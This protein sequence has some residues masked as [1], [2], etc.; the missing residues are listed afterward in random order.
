MSNSE[1][2]AI[3]VIG[4]SGDLARKKIYPALFALF[5]QH[6][7]PEDFAVF[8]F[9]RSAYSAAEFR[10]KVAEHLTCRYTPDDKACAALMDQ[11]LA[12]CHAH[13]GVYGDTNSYLD[14]FERLRDTGGFHDA[15]K[16]YYMAIPPTVFLET[17]RAMANSGLVPC[18][19]KP[20]WARTVIEKPFGRDRR[21]SDELASGLARVFTERQT[22]RIDHYL[23]K[24]V[25]QNVLAIRFANLIF[26]PIWN[27]EYVESVEIVWKENIGTSGRGGY[28][29]QFGI[30]RDV[31]QNHLLQILAMIA[32]ER[33]AALRAEAV[34]DS[35]VAVL[36]AIAPATLDNSR[37]GQYVAGRGANGR[38]EEGYLDDPTVPPGSLTP[39]F[40]AVRLEVN[41]PRWR[42]VPFKII[43]GKGAD[44]KKNEV[45]IRFKPVVGNLFCKAE[46]CPYQNELVIRIQPS[47][48][49]HLTITGKIPGEKLTFAPADLDLSYSRA[50]AGREIPDAY[51]SLLLDVVNGEKGLFIRDDELAAAWDIFTPLLHDIE[52]RKVAPQPYP[53]G[54]PAIFRF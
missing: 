46:N 6:R 53:F 36:K 19:D 38:D 11:F 23:G 4:G 20:F 54:D 39:T 49:M 41:N 24:E 16:I 31:V 32:M 27:A 1:R 29:D 9:A 45:R 5:C 35:K 22:Y 2:L 51:E 8:S 44:E 43:A 47:E 50:F 13:Q 40:A 48:G 26:E 52:T 12:R 42:G 3:I 7:L 17:A 28:F 18:G 15:D 25:V 21:S 34:R 10:E 37:L 14:L 33:P 30:I